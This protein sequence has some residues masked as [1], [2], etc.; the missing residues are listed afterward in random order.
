[1]SLV[2]APFGCLAGKHGISNIVTFSASQEAKMTAAPDIVGTETLKNGLTVTIRHLRADDRERVAKAVRELDR[3]SVYTRLFSYRNELTD[4]GLDRIMAVDPERDVTL[5]V[6]TGAGPEEIVIGSGRYIASEAPGTAGRAAEIAFVVAT[7]CQ[8]LGIAG[9]LLARLA[10]IG[11]GQGI[12]HFQADVLAENNS[13]L[14]VFARS[15]LP[16]QRRRDG[17]VI[18]VSLSLGVAE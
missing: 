8:R 9:R 17:G 18:H 3:E 12:T 6:A 13:M 5:L 1:M 14:A 2:G 7:N 4:A 10:E 11:R 15:G 16:M